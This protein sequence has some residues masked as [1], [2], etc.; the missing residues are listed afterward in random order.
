MLS[1]CLRTFAAPAALVLALAPAGLRAQHA[2]APPV[3]VCAA[4][5]SA[6]DLDRKIDELI[7]KM[8]PEERVAQLQDR[9]PAI[10]RLGIPAYN[11]WNEGLHGIA[12]NGHATVFPQAIGMAASFDPALLHAAGETIGTEARAKFNPH[13]AQDSA[14]YAGLTIWSPNI[15]IFRDPRWGRGQ[16]TYGED[17]YLTGQLGNAFVEGIQGPEAFY[18]RADATAK[19]FVAHSGPESIRDGFN[20][21]VT[22]HDLHDTYLAA[23]HT[24]TTEGHV[25][26]IMCSY[27]A[28]NGTPTCGYDELLGQTVRGGWGFKGYVVSDCDAIGEIADY[29]HFAQ[30]QPHGAAVALR[31]GTDLNCGGAYFHLNEALKQ[32]L[33]NESQIHLALHRLLRT[34]LRLGMLQ[35]AG[36]SPYEK[37]GPEQ[38]DTAA[39]RALALRAAEESMVLLENKGNL[40]PYN[41]AGKKIAI[42]GP[43]ADSIEEMEANYH[44]TIRNPKTLYEGLRATLPADTQLFYAQGAAL[45]GGVA[46]PVARTAL[47]HAGKPGLLGEYFANTKL[48]GPPA[49]TRTDARVDFD[50][51]RIEP[52]PGAGHDYAIRWTGQLQPPAP[53][54]Y[55][56]HVQVDRCFD[57]KGHDGYALWV[58]GEKQLDDNGLPNPHQKQPDSVVFDWTDTKPHAIRLELAHTGEDEGIHLLWEVPAAAQLDEARRV[59]RDA[60]LI[61]ATVG[62]SSNL[63]GEALGIKIPGF[64]GGDRETLELPA[65]QRAL[66]AALNELHKPVVVALSSGSAVAPD[67]EMQK[68]QAILE[69]W[70]PGEAGGEAL[71]HLLS[72]QANPSGRL[73]V[74]I[75]RS[76][77]DL[78]AFTDYSM[79]HRTYRYFDGAVAYGFGYGLSYSSFSYAKTSPSTRRLRAGGTLQI[80]T[81]VR[82]S[83]NRAGDE[84]VELYLK[85]PAVAGAP[86]IELKGFER[87]HLAAKASK[88]VRFTLAA[89][90]LKLVDESGA[91][92]LVPGRY[93]IFVGGAQPDTAQKPAASFEIVAAH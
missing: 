53:G 9:A 36:C 12:R 89:D 4:T 78:P 2:A 42:I 24:L 44:G 67:T 40:L 84:V 75:Y 6:N 48:E 10:P 5:L 39:S 29:L 63:E 77:N 31:A 79:A 23:F 15:N 1:A 25:S 37:I 83:S 19:H 76:V 22:P 50:L 92:T 28:L 43:T 32:G 60:D 56:L 21:K 69:T 7:A 30:D 26:S 93:E 57:C 17:P 49:V 55:R 68:A 74:T 90:K 91:H 66:L 45:A 71:A 3:P 70:Y 62:L 73:P 86:R 52:A 65:A 16:E 38:I 51:D 59:A 13:R 35:P 11:W 81:T 46:V 8:T 54:R 58:D 34:R 82:N 80:S 14:R 72:G 61:I 18:R 20:S 64:N 33:V 47:T 87:V 85:P 41:F 27:N 88:R